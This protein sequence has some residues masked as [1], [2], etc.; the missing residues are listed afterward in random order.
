MTKISQIRQNAIRDQQDLYYGKLAA[1]FQD[2]IRP[3]RS[4][5][6]TNITYLR[7]GNLLARPTNVNKPTRKAKICK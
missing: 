3:K 2:K 5:I 4:Q 7:N 6:E 1:K